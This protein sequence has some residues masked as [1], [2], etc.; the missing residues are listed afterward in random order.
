MSAGGA[1]RSLVRLAQLAASAAPSL[2][3][4]LRSGETDDLMRGLADTA[5]NGG[6]TYVKLGQLIAS[7][8][9]LV[10][11][12]IADMFAG[13]RDSVPPAPASAVASVL[14]SSGIDDELRSWDR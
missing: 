10:P 12:A 9:G 2:A 7:T 6:P 8:R 11:D 5:L 14:R 4:A 1:G 3:Q 13:C